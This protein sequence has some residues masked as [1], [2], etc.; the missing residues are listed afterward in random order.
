MRVCLYLCVCVCV[1]VSVRAGVISMT[2]KIQLVLDYRVFIVDPISLFIDCCF[3][4]LEGQNYIIIHFEN[5]T[6]EDRAVLYTHLHLQTVTPSLHIS[7][8][9]PSSI[10]SRKWDCTQQARWTFSISRTL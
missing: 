6:D 8:F 2:E 10:F 4:L 9:L 7:P 1:L 5:V 3:Q